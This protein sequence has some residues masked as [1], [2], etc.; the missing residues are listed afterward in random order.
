MLMN[1]PTTAF[2]NNQGNAYGE[3]K[4]CHGGEGPF[5]FRD[6][7][8][9]A[10][11]RLFVK[12][13]H[14]DVIRPGSSFGY[15]AHKDGT[16]FFDPHFEELFICLSGEGMMT[17]DGKDYVMKPGDIGI[18]YANGMHGIK[19]TGKEDMRILVVAGRPCTVK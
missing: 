16:A 14:D 9:G 18:C 6:L 15:H 4:N 8:N 2:I 11:D 1:T 10:S 12:C 3:H 17:L 13:V 5:L 19:N 7:M